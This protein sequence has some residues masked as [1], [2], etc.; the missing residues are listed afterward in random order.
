MQLFTFLFISFALAVSS[1]PS[2]LTDG[3]IDSLPNAE[4]RDTGGQ[5]AA[6]TVRLDDL[7][8][9][10]AEDVINNYEKALETTGMSKEQ[11]WDTIHKFEKMISEGDA[12]QVINDFAHI[13]SQPGARKILSRYE[14]LMSKDEA[15]Q[16]INSWE[17]LMNEDGARQTIGDLEK[18]FKEDGAQQVVDEYED[19]LKK[20]DGTKLENN[21]QKSQPVSADDKQKVISEYNKIVEGDKSKAITKY[22]KIMSELGARQIISDYESMVSN[23]AARQVISS[24]EKMM[25]EEVS[26]QV[27]SN[28]ARIM[29]KEEGRRIIS[30]YP[31]LAEDDE[32]SA[33]DAKPENTFSKGFL[34]PT[35]EPP[36]GDVEKI[37][38]EKKQ[39]SDNSARV[40]PA[41]IVSGSSATVSEDDARKI[42]GN[43]DKTL[44]HRDDSR[45]VISNYIRSLAHD[46]AEL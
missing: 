17:S 41:T 13:I 9:V 11:A 44:S 43:Y 4:T 16:T 3:E 12:D 6:H 38:V 15:R 39:R 23:E 33:P 26:R 28:Y 35:P 21:S 30:N 34:K 22:N 2:A 8:Q 45:L 25:G 5:A 36:K 27:I 10:D 20:T 7:S 18:L 19:S 37:S 42:I 32:K 29:T 46:S 40:L 14:E 31:S 24:Y 1:Q